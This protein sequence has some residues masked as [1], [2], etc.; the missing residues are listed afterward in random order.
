VPSASVVALRLPACLPERLTLP[1]GGSACLHGWE[2]VSKGIALSRAG[3]EKGRDGK[4]RECRSAEALGV[5]ASSQ[6]S[7]F[8]AESSRQGKAGALWACGPTFPAR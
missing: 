4:S 6:S 3:L 5:L 2:R 7:L 1:K 8:E